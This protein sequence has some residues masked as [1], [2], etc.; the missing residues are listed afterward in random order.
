MCG[1][2][3]CCCERSNDGILIFGEIALRGEPLL[4]RALISDK[5]LVFLYRLR[6]HG[7]LRANLS[8]LR[9]LTSLGRLIGA[10]VTPPR[11]R[12][13]R[14]DLEALEEPSLRVVGTSRWH[15]EIPTAHGLSEAGV[16]DNK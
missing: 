3:P 6:I 13:V 16:H 1:N 9:A 5:A 2:A 7:M 15:E 11:E 10:L 14:Q 12:H 4:V 8:R